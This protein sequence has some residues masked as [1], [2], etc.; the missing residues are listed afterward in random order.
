MNYANH[1]GYTDITP[2]EIVR[3]VSPKTIEIRGV[4]V[5]L[6]PAWKPEFVGRGYSGICTN[7]Q[8]QQWKYYKDSEAKTFRARLNKKGEWRSALGLHILCDKP[9]KYYDYNY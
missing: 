4:G 9:V 5:E 2:Y 8:A 1:R 6:D 7:Q 3:W